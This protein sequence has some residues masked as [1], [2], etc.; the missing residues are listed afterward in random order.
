MLL[1]GGR[2]GEVRSGFVAFDA[3]PCTR[4]PDADAARASTPGAGWR[5]RGRSETVAAARDA[6]AEAGCARIPIIT[7]YIR[8]RKDRAERF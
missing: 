4:G 6:A 5:A 2:C 3:G 8:G 7:R 1:A